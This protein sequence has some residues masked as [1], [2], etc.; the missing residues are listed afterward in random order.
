[1]LI[2]LHTHTHPGSWDS[3]LH[4]DELIER[5]KQ[6]GLDGIV[7]SEHDWA[8]DPE[9]VRALARRHDFLVLAGMEINTEDGH[10]LVYGMHKY[11]FG[12]HRAHEL[13]GHVE[14]ARG[15]MVAAHPYR[16]QAPWN[17]DKPQEY[18]DALLRAERNPAYRFVAALE[19]LNGRG[20]VNEN[21]FAQDLAANMGMT[22]TGGTDSH[23]R[24]DIGKT[25]TYFEREI[26]TEAELITEIRAGRCWAVDL[27]QGSLTADV[28]RHSVPE[29][30]HHRWDALGEQRRAHEAA[31]PHVHRP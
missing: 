5:A 8:W 9:A 2:D 30:L 1:M 26:R 11:V 27:T 24:S 25:A 13:A 3:F 28:V 7:L 14:D 12:M 4:P 19:V 15:V 18:L 20:N 16:R 21:R 6:A 23:Q 10:M 29:D 17:W 22:G 31:G